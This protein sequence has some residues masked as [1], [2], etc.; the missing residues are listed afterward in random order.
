MR[1]YGFPAGQWIV[2]V[3][4]RECWFLDRVSDTN[5]SAIGPFSLEIP[6]NKSAR[7]VKLFMFA[8]CCCF[9]DASHDSWKLVFKRFAHTGQ[10]SLALNS[11]HPAPRCTHPERR[12]Q[13]LLGSRALLLQHQQQQAATDSSLTSFVDL[14]QEPQSVCN[15]LYNLS[16][17]FCLY[18]SCLCGRAT[19]IAWQHGSPSPAAQPDSAPLFGPVQG[20]HVPTVIA[21]IT[22]YTLLI[23]RC[24]ICPSKVFVKVLARPQILRLVVS[25]MAMSQTSHNLP[26]NKT[27]GPCRCAI[28]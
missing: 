8:S 12:S 25:R 3:S 28:S 9:V 16:V 18:P 13:W 21:F 7:H 11:V 27:S 15:I 22:C 5:R 26:W 4:S 23:M 19:S 10:L 2:L 24:G 6:T 20:H 17:I 1:C 14:L